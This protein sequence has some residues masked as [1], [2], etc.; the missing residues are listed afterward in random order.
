MSRLKSKLQKV[1]VGNQYSDLYRKAELAVSEYVRLVA[2][3][4]LESD[5]NWNYDTNEFGKDFSNVMENDPEV[6]KGVTNK[7]IDQ[8]IAAILQDYPYSK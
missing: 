7:L 8:E 4:E 3:S 2:L 1:A 5:P 6:F